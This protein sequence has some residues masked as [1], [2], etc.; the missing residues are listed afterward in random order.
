MQHII[1]V[2]GNPGSYHHQVANAIY[3]EACVCRFHASFEAVVTEVAEQGTAGVLA[4]KNS[5]L[6]AISSNQQLLDATAI[7]VQSY[8]DLPIEHHLITAQVEPL[9]SITVVYS[10][11]AALAQVRPWLQDR[12]WLRAEQASDTAGAV[13]SICTSGQPHHAAIASTYAAQYYGGHVVA[14]IPTHHTNITRFALIAQKGTTH[15]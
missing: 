2:F 10:H 7:Q 9:E 8:Y 13:K 15:V 5:L 14:N 1:S 11:P 4:V 3:G 6:G 12:P